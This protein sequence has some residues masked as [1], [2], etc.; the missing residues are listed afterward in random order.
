MKRQWFKPQA[1][2]LGVKFTE[3]GQGD[4]TVDFQFCGFVFTRS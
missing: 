4:A 3:L 1:K 2:E